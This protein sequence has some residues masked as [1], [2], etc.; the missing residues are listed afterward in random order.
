M[1]REIRE[2]DTAGCQTNIIVGF[3]PL[4]SVEIE[5]SI[6]RI[7]EIIGGFQFFDPYQLQC[8]EELGKI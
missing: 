7:P 2:Q 1:E 3:V 5:A 6:N 4:D 8:Q